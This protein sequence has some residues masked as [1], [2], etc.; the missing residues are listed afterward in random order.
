MFDFGIILFLT[1]A[2]LNGVVFAHL[3]NSAKMAPNI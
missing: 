3:L 1:Q 2:A